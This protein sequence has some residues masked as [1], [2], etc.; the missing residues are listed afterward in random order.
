MKNNLARLVLTVIL[1]AGT[2]SSASAAP[3]TLVIFESTAEVAKRNDTSDIGTAYWGTYA[4]FAAEAGEAGILR[5]GSALDVAD[6]VYAVVGRDGVPVAAGAFDENAPLRLSG[7]FQIDVADAAAAIT[8]AEKIP[9][10]ATGRIEVR[11][12]YPAPGMK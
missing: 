9:A 7:Y 8:W 3:F 6:Q 2:V 4:R 11:A 5:G 1:A 10:A 12:G